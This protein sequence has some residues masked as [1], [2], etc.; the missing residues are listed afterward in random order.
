MKGV[1]QITRP[2]NGHNF[3]QTGAIS[4]GCFFAVPLPFRVEDSDHFFSQRHGF[5]GQ[6][7]FFPS[8]KSVQLED[9]GGI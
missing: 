8:G 5:H 3:A 4:R 7:R 2:H 1:G 9:T 6:V